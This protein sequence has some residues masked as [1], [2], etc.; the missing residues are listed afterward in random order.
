MIQ[1][2]ERGMRMRKSMIIVLGLVLIIVLSSCGSK[3][4]SYNDGKYTAQGDKWEYGYEEADVTI[5]NSKIKG[6][7]LKRLDSKGE[8]VDYEKWTGK[9]INGQVW[10][11]LKQYRVDLA[12]KM[13]EK[14][15]YEV[16]S[17]S[18]ATISCDNWK[19]AVERALKKAG[20]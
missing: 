11:N 17:I 7:N 12:D 3:D 6:I 2:E 4:N 18:G 16:D 13:I 10:P 8:E 9:K 5:V 14:Q 20:E 1:D 15:S 19:T